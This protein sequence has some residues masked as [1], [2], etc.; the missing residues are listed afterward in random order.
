MTYRFGRDGRR[1]ARAGLQPNWAGQAGIAT[2]PH[3]VEGGRAFTFTH[4]PNPTRENRVAVPQ[5]AAPMNSASPENVWWRMCLNVPRSRKRRDL[6]AA[7]EEEGSGK[8]R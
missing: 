8:K 5:N 4:H 2:A 6:V 3:R 1:Y 7:A